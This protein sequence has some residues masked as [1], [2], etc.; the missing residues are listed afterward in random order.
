MTASLACEIIQF[1]LRKNKALNKK[2]HVFLNL[3][4]SILLNPIQVH[5]LIYPW[6]MGWGFWGL[7]TA[8]ALPLCF[9]GAAVCLTH[10]QAP[11]AAP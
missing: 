6:T 7:I 3:F 8:A 4:L 10:C 1:S 9:E 5:F 11:W 2:S